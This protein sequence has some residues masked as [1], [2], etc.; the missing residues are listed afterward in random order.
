MID[1]I[2]ALR[3]QLG[4]ADRRTTVR[5]AAYRETPAWI[6]CSGERML[7]I[8][9]TPTTGPY[10]D[11]GV[12]IV[13]GGPQYRVG[14]HRQFVRLARA[15]ARA[16]C[17][18]LRF[19]HRGMGDSEGRRRSFEDINADLQ[20]A[21][22]FL[23]AQPGVRRIVVWGLCD[24]A[25]AALMFCAS[26]S[27]VGGLVLLNPWVRSEAALATT[28]L[29]H[30]YGQRLLER[31]FWERLFAG[32]FD[33]RASLRDFVG[34]ARAAALGQSKARRQTF[35]RRMAEGWQRFRGPILLILSGRDLTAKEFLEHAATDEAWRGLIEQRD[36]TRRELVEADHTF[37][38][39]RAERWMREQTID[40]IFRVTAAGG[41]CR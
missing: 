34:K 7:G 6:D 16:G 36:V 14:S 22:D 32:R 5:M 1:M 13:V 40:W 18:S 21:L 10:A 11:V 25:S 17:V 2:G 3:G 8:I 23:S 27:R 9:S 24:A 31:E 41:S 39:E 4:T 37:S 12:L 15:L 28:H 19:D 26:D 30:Y 33:W 38:G 20:A 35:Q 29:K